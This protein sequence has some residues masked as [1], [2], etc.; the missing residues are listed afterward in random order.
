MMEVSGLSLVSNMLQSKV[1]EAGQRSRELAAPVKMSGMPEAELRASASWREGE[2]SGSINAVSGTL[3]LYQRMDRPRDPDIAKSTF[4]ESYGAIQ[5]QQEKVQ[6]AYNNVLLQ[7]TSSDPGLA[8]KDFGFSVAEDGRLTLTDTASLSQQQQQ[9]VESAL[10]ASEDLVSTANDYARLHIQLT[11][12][13]EVSMYGKFQLDLDNYAETI[14]IGKELNAIKNQSGDGNLWYTQLW[15]K[16]D[17]RYGGWQRLVNS[18][19]VDAPDYKPG[20]LSVYEV[21]AGLR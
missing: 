1:V 3:T 15:S 19:W 6:S 13:D 8:G 16:G 12:S 5:A 14:D 4:A 2:M 17:E 10:N 7:L 20:E 21:I 9:Q 18:E 11:E